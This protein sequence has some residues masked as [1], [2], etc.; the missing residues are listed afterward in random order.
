MRRLAFH[1]ESLCLG[2]PWNKVMSIVEISEK[3]WQGILKVQEE[4]YTGVPPEEVDVLK[5]KWKASPETCFVFQSS[6]NEILGYLLAHPW[7]SDEPPKL[8]EE[9]PRKSAGDTLYL[10]DL[11]V[12]NNARE[13]GI[14]KQLSSKL[15]EV[16]KLR[17]F[18][19]VLLVAVQGSGGY[20]SKFGFREVH[21]ASICSSYGTNAKLMSLN[22]QA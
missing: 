9:L 6:S 12:S 19:R 8:F 17:Q 20:W 7:N 13:S 21:N 15:I 14:G 5:S 11:A 4:A 10:H 18:N 2:H 22:V 16:A 1:R 3:S